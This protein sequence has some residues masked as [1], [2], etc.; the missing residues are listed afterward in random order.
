MM[1][2]RAVQAIVTR[3]TMVSQHDRLKL[4]LRLHMTSSISLRCAHLAL[5][6]GLYASV[7]H[8]RSYSLYPIG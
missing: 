7:F 2:R 4:P 1:D 6:V 5:R 8:S 3:Q